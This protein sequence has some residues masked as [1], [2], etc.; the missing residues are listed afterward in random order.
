M[1]NNKLGIASVVIFLIG[2][3]SAI[4]MIIGVPTVAGYGIAFIVFPII[5]I[6]GVVAV[7]YI[8]HYSNENSEEKGKNI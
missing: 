5:A 4:L 1:N 3:V 7:I 8:K 2:I 6:S